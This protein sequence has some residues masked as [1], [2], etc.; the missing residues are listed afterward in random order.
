MSFLSRVC[1]KSW[2]LTDWKPPRRLAARAL[3]G[4]ETSLRRSHTRANASSHIRTSRGG[5][6]GF[7]GT[8]TVTSG[9]F[10]TME[11]MSWTA[12]VRTVSSSSNRESQAYTQ[13]TLQLNDPLTPRCIH[14]IDKPCGARWKRLGLGLGLLDSCFGLISPHQQSTPF[15]YLQAPYTILNL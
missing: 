3:T 11:E 1:S 4:I 7:W 5:T 2:G 12:T 13:P 14:M 8:D 15:P 6:G 10:W 9:V